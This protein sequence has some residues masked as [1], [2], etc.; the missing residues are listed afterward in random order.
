MSEH[1]V[2]VA[3]RE[4]LERA[5]ASVVAQRRAY[6]HRLEAIAAL[7]DSGLAPGTGYRSLE[8]L[9]ADRDNV[10]HAEA[11]RLV[12]EAAD[13]CTRS[14]LLGEVLPARLPCTGRGLS[15]G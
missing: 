3:E 13:L 1:G 7:A 6:F 5:Q 14:S 12:A 15:A 8:A 9:L 11:K 4:A 10:D 2:G